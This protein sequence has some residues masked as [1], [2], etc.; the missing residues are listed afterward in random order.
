MSSRPHAPLPLIEAGTDA[1]RRTSVAMFIGGFT[2]FSLL[3]ATQPILPR[4]AEEFHAPPASISLAVSLGTA[5]LALALLPASIL[6]DRHGRTAL[7]KGALA[8]APLM[9]LGS[10]LATDFN[11]L[12]ILRVLLG[13]VLAGLPAAAMAYLGEEVAPTAQGKAMG[14]YIAG[15]A[16]GGMSGRFL[17]ALLTDLS[18]WRIALATLAL[19]GIVAACFFW[20][21]LPASRHFRQR[22]I[23][24][25]AVAADMRALIADRAMRRLLA[26]AF[27]LMGGFTSLYNYLGFRLHAAP[28]SLSQSAVGAVF[29]LYLVGTFSSAWTGNL[30]DRIGRRNVL[31]GMIVVTGAG[32][33][34]TL[35]NQLAAIVAG[36]AVFT[37]GY[38]GAHTSASGWVGRRAGERRALGA[39]LYLCAYYLGGSVIGTL[40][41]LAWEHA[42][43]RGIATALGLAIGGALLI[44]LDLRKVP[45]LSATPACSQTR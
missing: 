43:W 44:A 42:A 33:A 29:L 45:A 4:L 5:G 24:P 40:S 27:L 25:A 36:V 26:V 30:V 10:A 12:L 39:A 34:L 20:R 16:L 19:M 1:F 28:F 3:Y 35:A 18:T 13:I 21:S 37:F 22:V 11:V 41:G 32:L 31:W 17:V 8:L 2:T 38:F 15:N 14:L 6:A 9:A 7:M 23:A